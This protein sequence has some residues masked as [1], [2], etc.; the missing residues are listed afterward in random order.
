MVTVQ[1]ASIPER[2]EI[3]EIVVDSLREQAQQI[4]VML[5]NYLKTPDFLKRS[6]INVK[7]LDNSK[8]DGAKFY[9]LSEAQGYVFTC[10]D[11]LIY[12]ENYVELTVNEL[13]KYENR[14]ILSHHGR[15]M[16]E[17]PVRNSYTD[18][19]AA[20]HW[21]VEQLHATE[22]SIGGT[23][24]MCWHSDH[25]F[26]DYDKIT[27]KNM[28]DIWIAKFAKEQGVKIMLCPHPDQWIEYLH[29]KDT[30]WNRD[31]PNPGKQTDLYNSF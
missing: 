18:R 28:A 12:P 21:N 23:G 3:L 5:N 29:P 19:K 26:P 1:I 24:V 22:L 30:I 27:I 31:Y 2:E 17:K 25:F 9:G 20:F 11:D 7:H 15:I 4:N 13:K 14:V 8:G 10:D 6:W 16:Q